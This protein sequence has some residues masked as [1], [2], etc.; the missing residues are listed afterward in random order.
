MATELSNY[1]RGLSKMSQPAMSA[2][3]SLG[4]G[5]EA[6]IIAGKHFYKI[7]KLDEWIEKVKA[8][9]KESGE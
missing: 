2:V 5:P 1:S 3:V 4:L 6:E 7:S 9:V 8:G